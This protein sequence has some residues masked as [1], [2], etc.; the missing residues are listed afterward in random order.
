VAVC[1]CSA[2]SLVFGCSCRLCLLLVGCGRGEDWGLWC[3]L[4]VLRSLSRCVCCVCQRD[5]PRAVCVCDGGI[6]G[7]RGVFFA[8]SGGGCYWPCSRCRLRPYRRGSSVACFLYRLVPAVEAVPA[9][10]GAAVVGEVATAAVEAVPA[11]G[12][13]CGGTLLRLCFVCWVT[14]SA[15]AASRCL[16]RNLSK[17]AESSVNRRIRKT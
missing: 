10:G 1:P 5:C 11:T 15:P 6:C 8:A 2:W 14:I 16:W 9:T 7:L 17:A 13:L 12:Y 3:C 4:S